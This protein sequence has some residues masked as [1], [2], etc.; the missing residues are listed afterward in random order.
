MV[1]LPQVSL[2][3]LRVLDVRSNYVSK[4]HGQIYT[5]VMLLRYNMQ[6]TQN[7]LYIFNTKS[8]KSRFN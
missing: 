1:A 6:P 5:T 4:T 8:Q 7:L 2:F 3:M